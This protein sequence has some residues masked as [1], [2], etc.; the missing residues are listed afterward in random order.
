MKPGN[1][2]PLSSIDHAM[3]AHSLHLV[4]YYPAAAFDGDANRGEALRDSISEMIVHFP[5]VAGRMTRPEELGGNWV[6][7]LTDTGI[8]VLDAKVAGDL[9]GWLSSASSEMEMELAQREVP[10]EDVFLWSPFT[11]QVCFAVLLSIFL[12]FYHFS[13]I[14]IL[15]E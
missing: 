10:G 12:T 2:F 15:K 1:T 3:A 9:E 5:A 13:W 11:L 8:R 7:K 14:R 6:M 4:F